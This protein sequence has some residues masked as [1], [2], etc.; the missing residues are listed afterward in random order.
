MIIIN[1]RITIIK[2]G[3]PRSQNIND[4]LQ[5]FGRSLGLFSLRDKDKSS[6]RVFIELLKSAKQQKAVSSDELAYKLNLTRGTV[7]HHLRK[8]MDAGIVISDKNKYQLRV[9]NLISLV[10]EIERDFKQASED[11][12]RVARDIDDKMR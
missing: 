10:E 4:E 11:L 8:L 1:Q 3:Q 2:S 12:K 6:F 5:W 9:D 7:V